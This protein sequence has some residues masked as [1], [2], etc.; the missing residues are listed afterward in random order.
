MD[1]DHFG[2]VEFVT[3][4]DAELSSTSNGV[5]GTIW[6]RASRAHGTIRSISRQPTDIEVNF[7]SVRRLQDGAFQLGDTQSASHP[8]ICQNAPFSLPNECRPW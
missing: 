1:D 2:I 8:A 6:V 4:Q 3:Q 5:T 7:T